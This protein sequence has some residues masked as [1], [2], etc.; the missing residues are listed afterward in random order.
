MN[1]KSLQIN[2]IIAIVVVITM[3]VFAN[4]LYAKGNMQ[5]E[6][7]TDN[8]GDLI[9]PDGWLP[10]DCKNLALDNQPLNAF[11]VIRLTFC[12]NLRIKSAWV[13]IKKYEA[14]VGIAKAGRLPRVELNANYNQSKNSN[15]S[16]D[17]KSEIQKQFSINLRQSLYDFGLNK[18]KVASAEKQVTSSIFDFYGQLVANAD[19]GVNFYIDLA[20]QQ[21]QLDSLRRRLQLSKVLHEI[22]KFNLKKGTVTISDTLEAEHD[23][24]KILINIESMQKDYQEALLRFCLQLNL[25]NCKQVKIEE[26]E[27]VELK[28]DLRVLLLLAYRTHPSI[29]ARAL[30]IESEVEQIKALEAEV[31][32]KFDLTANYYKNGRPSQ[33]SSGNSNERVVGVSMSYPIFDG[34]E[35]EYK[36]YSEKT[37]IMKG[38]IDKKSEEERVINGIVK[39]Y[40]NYLSQKKNY[41]EYIGSSEIIKKKILVAISRYRFGVGD[42]KEIIA[43]L[44]KHLEN[45]YDFIKARTRLGFAKYSVLLACGII[46]LSEFDAKE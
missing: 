46:N 35:N 40:L 1:A 2:K 42:I 23:I 33:A 5:K 19:E 8:I 31:M 32:P 9:L 38:L 3:F 10:V 20:T 24:K 13:E 30:Q 6:N 45:E 26:N 36:V 28:Y 27:D 37:K 17:S 14:D 18:A 34:F 11:D 41:E 22:A 44:N 43:E 12:N 16:T 4:E 29:L 39:A 21:M 25:N 7:F 15:N